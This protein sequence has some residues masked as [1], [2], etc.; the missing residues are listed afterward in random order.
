MRY[1]RYLV[2]VLLLTGI[3][4]SVG[5]VPRRG[6]PAL[7]P[8]VSDPTALGL[9]DRALAAL[10]PDQLQSLETNVWQKVLLPDLEY[11]ADG[12]YLMGSEQRYRLE[13]HTHIGSHVGTLLQVSDGECLWQATRSNGGDWDKVTRQYLHRVPPPGTTPVQPVS[14]ATAPGVFPVTGFTGVHPLLCNL[15]GR[16]AWTGQERVVHNGEEHMLLTGRWLP[17][18]AAVLVPPD[19]SWPACLPVECRLWLRTQDLWPAHMEW[20]GP[21]CEGGSPELLVCMEFRQP[22]RNMPL[23]SERCAAEFIFNPGEAKI[24]EVAGGLLGDVGSRGTK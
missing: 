2:A 7:A 10:D 11:E 24:V 8:S 20:W 23:S 3:L 9:L 18:V 4:V 1:T 15:R 22:R 12:T 19:Q 17:Q 14:A 13:V 21:R 6:S 5:A 16:L